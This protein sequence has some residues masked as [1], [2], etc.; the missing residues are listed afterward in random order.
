MS[1]RSLIEQMLEHLVSGDSQQAE[2]LFHEYVVRQSRS[3]YESLIEDEMGPPEGMDGEDNPMDLDGEDPTDDLAMDL[4]GEDDPS[5]D[6]NDDETSEL[7]ADLDDIVDSLEAK[8]KE[9][10]GGSEPADDDGEDQFGDEGD[11]EGED[12]GDQDL[13]DDFNRHTFREYTERVSSGHGAER[14]GQSEQADSGSSSL[15][16]SKNDMGGTSSNLLSGRNG[17]DAGYAG[18]AGGRMKGSALSDTSPQDMNT[19][20]LNKVGGY[21]GAPYSR[22]NAGHG[23]E[24]KGQSEKSTEG[25]SL[26]RGRR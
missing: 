19:G 26:F 25:Q 2:E 3:I 14:K 18:S 22:N 5:A 6:G 10:Q 12:D 16:F 4:D 21:K 9:L 23:A 17:Q 8:F 24:K 11:G 15:K 1:N 20:N 13:K 7:F